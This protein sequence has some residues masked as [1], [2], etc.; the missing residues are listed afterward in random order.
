MCVVA[1]QRVQV[2]WARC[3][4]SSCGLH[5]HQHHHGGSHRYLAPRPMVRAFPRTCWLVFLVHGASQGS[6]SEF[7]Q[8]D[9][10][11]PPWCL[12]SAGRQP[13]SCAD[14]WLGSKK[15][16]TWH[17]FWKVR[18]RAISGWPLSGKNSPRIFGDNF[19]SMPLSMKAATRDH[20]G[21]S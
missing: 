4:A 1:S 7:C 3:R 9:S 18:Y 2:Q 17:R 6:V 8:L 5:R 19:S 10:L 14:G 12:A 11:L 21:G 20:H 15:R 16:Q 13:V